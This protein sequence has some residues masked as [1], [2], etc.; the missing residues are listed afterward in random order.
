LKSGARDWPRLAVVGDV[1]V[2]RTGG[3]ALL[4]HRLLAA[5]PADRLLVVHNPNRARKDDALRLSGVTYRDFAYDIPWA[6]RKRINPLWPA[7]AAVW[8]QR[9]APAMLEHVRDFGADAILTVSHWYLWFAAAAAAR[10]QRLPLHLILHDDWAS[11]QTAYQA[12]AVRAITLKV[13]RRVMR[14]VYREAETRLCISPGMEEHGRA[15]F[16]VEGTVL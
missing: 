9:H 1:S 13:C 16:G 4:L 15:W 10:R 7:V 6:I 14:R 11:L 12:D 2:E 3:G 8:M 5:Y